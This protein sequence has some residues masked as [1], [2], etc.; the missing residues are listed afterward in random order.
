MNRKLV[1]AAASLAVVAITIGAQA[2]GGATGVVKQRMELM[3]SIGK[4][5]KGLSAMMRGKES[6]AVDRV[7]TLALQIGTH[8]G[9]NLT[10]FFPADSLMGPTEALPEIWQDWDRFSAL[11][12]QVSDYANALAAAA[13]NERT[14]SAGMGMTGRGMTPDGQG[15]MPRRPSMMQPRGGMG[16][17]EAM[18]APSA[19]RLAEMPPDAAFMHL[20]QTCT[21]CHQ[22]F[23][24]EK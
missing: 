17:G 1:W 19:E 9:E 3:D 21:A 8:G 10:R 15:T 16:M 24:K 14:G 7:R 18:R 20:T 12:E 22:T 6:Y 13:D 2:H 23:R 5:M 11:A 4:A